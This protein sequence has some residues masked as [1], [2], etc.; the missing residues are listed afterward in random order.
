MKARLPIAVLPLFF[1][2]APV[3]FA[4]PPEF[5]LSAG[6]GPTLGGLFTSY[7]ITA[8][9]TNRLGERVD[10][11]MTQEARQFTYGGW[12]FFDFT[13]GEFSVDIQGAVG[14]YTETAQGSRGT[15]ALSP[16]NREGTGSGASLGFTLLGK[17]PFRLREGLLIYPLLGI[18][19]RV[20]LAEKRKPQGGAK[21]NRPSGGPD[22]FDPDREYRLSLWNAFFIDLG[23]GVDV[24]FRSPL[25]LRG[26]LLYAIR[27][28]TGYENAALDW[29][30][31]DYAGGISRPKL[32]ANPGMSGL[33][34]GPELR[35]ALGYRIK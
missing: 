30:Q 20:A 29:L 24:Y 2:L 25:Y 13:Y 21:Y 15:G 33:T 34:H 31:E 27:F 12:V 10:L 6:G 14:S 32:F 35:L 1:A 19:Y 9:E 11:T 8:H 18:E 23:A 28:P 22:E 26:E 4:A 16:V 3:L 7:T 5:S 17:Y